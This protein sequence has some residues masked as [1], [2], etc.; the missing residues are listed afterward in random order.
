MRHGQDNAPD[1]QFMNLFET[2]HRVQPPL[3]GW[4]SP[5]KAEA[6]AA[7]VLATRSQVTVEVGIYGGSS[8]IPLALAHKEIGCGVCWGIDPWSKAASVKDEIPANVEFWER[9]DYEKLYG[10][11]MQALVNLELESCT[12]IIK[13]PSDEVEPP[14][15]ISVLHVDGAHTQQA[16]RDVE[17]FAVNVGPGGF[18]IMDDE[19]WTN[20]GVKRAC[21][22]LLDFGFK[23]LYPLGTGAVF[24]RL[25]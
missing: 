3:P 20:G 11:F 22:R 7:I 18:C 21:A 5:E 8:F 10:D 16:I 19:E 23:R 4:C 14:S 17:R 2:I 12:R 6:I 9:Q 15:D 1:A 25:I 24:Q 13:L